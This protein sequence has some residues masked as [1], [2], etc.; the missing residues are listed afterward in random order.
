MNQKRMRECKMDTI[1]S[2]I[3][4]ITL[5]LVMLLGVSCGKPLTQDSNHTVTVRGT[6][7]T[8][9]GLDL[10][11]FYTICRKSHPDDLDEQEECV[12]RFTEGLQSMLDN[13]SASLLD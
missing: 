13:N 12:D 5:I 8:L 1:Y 3:L 2:A 7:R 11:Q 4:V 9:F 6:T 10:S